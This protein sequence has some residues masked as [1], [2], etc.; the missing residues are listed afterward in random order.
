MGDLV[1]ELLDLVDMLVLIVQYLLQDLAR[2]EISPLSSQ[3]YPRIV[4][5]DGH[6]FGGIT[7]S[8]GC[9]G[10]RVNTGMQPATMNS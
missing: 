4:P 1:L 8:A 10:G 2:R 3:L 6:L 9:R 5:R 7:S